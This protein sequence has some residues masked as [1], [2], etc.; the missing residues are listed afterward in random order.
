MSDRLTMS[1][2]VRGHPP[3]RE[4]DIAFRQALGPTRI[5]EAAR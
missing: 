3:G 2:L 1:R 5:F 4:F